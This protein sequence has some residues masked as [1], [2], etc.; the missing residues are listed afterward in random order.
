M[1]SFLRKRFQWHRCGRPRIAAE[2]TNIIAAV[3]TGLEGL[4]MDVCPRSS[5]L[6]D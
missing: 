2:I 6:T 5:A 4:I 1:V 3:G